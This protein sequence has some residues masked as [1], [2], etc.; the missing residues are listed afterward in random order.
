MLDRLQSGWPAAFARPL[1]VPIAVAALTACD[2]PAVGGYDKLTHHRD[3]VY[4]APDANPP[5]PPLPP[6]AFGGAAT[7]VIATSLPTGVTQE[8]VNEGQELFGTVCVACHGAGGAGSTIAP[9][10][11]DDDWLNVSGEYEEII[12]I[13]NNGVAQPVE[14]PAPMPPQGGGN[15]TDDEVQALGAYVYALSH[16]GGDA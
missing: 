12:T 4:I 10:L 7:P 8:M 5:P 14:Y 6:G 15:F 1:L 13:I 9:P 16:Q 11:N 3:E 2:P